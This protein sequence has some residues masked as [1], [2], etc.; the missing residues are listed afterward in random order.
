MTLNLNIKDTGSKDV[1]QFDIDNVKMSLVNA[2]RR[3]MISEVNTVAFETSEFENS[4]IKITENTSQFHNEFLLHRIGLIPINIPDTENFNE[5]DYTFSLDIENKT[6]NV[7]Y[8]TA[9]DIKVMNNLTGN[10]EPNE[11]FFPKDPISNDNIMI[12]R[13]LPNPAGNSE[14]LSFTGTAR[15]GNGGDDARYSPTSVCFYTNTIDQDAMNEAYNKYRGENSDGDTE[16]LKKRFAINESERHFVRDAE[17][18]PSKFS[19]TV[20]SIGMIP[21][22]QILGRA[23]DILN[24]KLEKLQTELTKKDSEYLEI[25]ETPTAMEAFDIT[26]DKE[27]HTLGFVIQE[28][29]NQLISSSDLVYVGYMN[30]H[31]LK[32]NIKL[33]VALTQN[34]RDNLVKQITFVCQNIANQCNSIK[35]LVEQ[36][37]GSIGMKANAGPTG[38]DASTKP[39]KKIRIKKKEP[40]AEGREVTEAE[41]GEVDEAS[42]AGE[43]DEDTS[44]TPE[45]TGG[46]YFEMTDN[47][48]DLE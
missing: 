28:H 3:I 20:E 7:L 30:P 40:E 18:E 23:I 2:L 13:L 34:N 17:G 31:P 39:K 16:K 6:N 45:M 32:K 38:A 1:L 44:T 26:I 33:R 19:F 47:D 24:G 35:S 15:V 46:E 22:E 11:K 27:S 41:A 25:E 4:S 48:S 12:V 5:S 8:V 43:V 21:P 36:K 29:A 42:E 10:E 14:K 37:Y 9:G